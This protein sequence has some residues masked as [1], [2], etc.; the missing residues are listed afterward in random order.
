MNLLVFLPFS[1]IPCETVNTLANSQMWKTKE[2]S[3]PSPRMGQSK[4]EAPGASSVSSA[5]INH[6]DTGLY[7]KESVT[8][9]SVP[10]NNWE[11]LNPKTQKTWD[12]LASVLAL[13]SLGKAPTECFDSLHFPLKWHSAGRCLA[14][15]GLI[16]PLSRR[17]TVMGSKY[18]WRS[19]SSPELLECPAFT[20]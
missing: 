4:W 8:W 15:P 16:L 3:H 11:C 18:L 10:C 9:I 2:T 20:F 13:S 1:Q 12:C 19:T 14:P 7:K 17:Q 6:F 5:D